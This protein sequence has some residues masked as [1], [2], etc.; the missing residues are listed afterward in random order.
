VEVFDEV[1]TAVRELA[2]A[3]GSVVATQLA[4]PEVNVTAEQST[5]PER[6]PS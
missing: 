2:V 3:T 5:V 4:A 1:K 6:P